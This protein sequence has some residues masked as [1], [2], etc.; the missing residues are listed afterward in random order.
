M[1]AFRALSARADAGA[2]QP[3]P[4]PH[5]PGEPAVPA[6]SQPRKPN[7]MTARKPRQG[8]AAAAETPYPDFPLTPHRGAKPC[9]KKIRGKLR[10]FGPPDDWRR[11]L[12]EYQRVRDELQAGRAPT[13]LAAEDFAAFRAAPARGRSRSAT[14]SGAA[15]SCSS[16]P[17][18]TG[19]TRGW[20]IARRSAADSSARPVRR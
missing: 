3:F 10:Y 4:Q 16:S 1:I 20:S 5:P 15:G 7:S 6:R 18:T 2:P 8:A 9:C 13:S 14:P 19:W 12:E 17:M 11:A